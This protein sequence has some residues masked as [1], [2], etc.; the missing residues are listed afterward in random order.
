MLD[1]LMLMLAN[2]GTVLF[3]CLAVVVGELSSFFF[4]AFWMVL[5]MR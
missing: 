1:G 5:F 3:S 2:L 4:M